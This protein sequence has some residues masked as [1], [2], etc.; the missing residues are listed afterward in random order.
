MT[1]E[2]GTEYQLSECIQ[3]NFNSAKAITVIRQ[4]GNIIQFTLN[5]L[6]GHGSMPLQHLQYLMK[7]NQITKATN[8]RDFLN[9]EVE[10]DQIV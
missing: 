5:D 8:K 3:K 2:A 7:K 9:D 1:I 6:N 10:K 4:T